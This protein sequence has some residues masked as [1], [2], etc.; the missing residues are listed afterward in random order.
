MAKL[1]RERKASE[2][3]DTLHCGM[4]RLAF[5]NGPET[6]IQYAVFR[7][8][9]LFDENHMQIPMRAVCLDPINPTV[10]SSGIRA[11]DVLRAFVWELYRKECS[12]QTF[13]EAERLEGLSGFMELSR[14]RSKRKRARKCRS[15]WWDGGGA[16]DGNLGGG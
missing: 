11:K 10:L 16:I 3:W 8:R 2:G 9:Y 5:A 12:R 4:A 6:D 13:T 1:K 15:A 14:R 7:I